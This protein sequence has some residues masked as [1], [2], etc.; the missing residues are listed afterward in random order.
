MKHYIS[1][2]LKQMTIEELNDV[3]V[4]S[5]KIITKFAEYLSNSQRIY[6]NELTDAYVK[7]TDDEVKGAY[8]DL[9]HYMNIT[10]HEL[11]N[12][13]LNNISIID[14]AELIK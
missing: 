14:F 7:A 8:I 6:L 13:Y 5:Q 11:I 2:E 10:A 4:A 12:D 1:L 9:V 3:R